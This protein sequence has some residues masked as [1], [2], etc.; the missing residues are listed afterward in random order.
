MLWKNFIKNKTSKVIDKPDT[1]F[2]LGIFIKRKEELIGDI[3]IHFLSDNKQCEIGYTLSSDYQ[4]KG[5]ATEAVR[6][7][8]NYLFYD[9]KKHRIIASVD[10]R[11]VKSIEL[12]KR[13]GMRKEAH[14]KKSIWI[15][16]EWADDIIYAILREEW[17]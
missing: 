5:Y 7:V 6:S 2:Q 11:N 4:G 16:N 17:I 12:L 13:I 9:L 14:F 3:G 8:I 10:P 15:N 1:W